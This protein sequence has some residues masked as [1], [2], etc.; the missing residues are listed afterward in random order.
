MA[1]NDYPAPTTWLELVQWGKDHYRDRCFEKDAL[2]PTRPGL[3]YIVHEGVVRLS[4]WTTPC[5]KESPADESETLL[6]FYRFY[7]PFE[8]T[9]SSECALNA[10]AHVN[11]T[12]VIWLYWS[13][14]HQWPSLEQGVF[15]KFHYHQQRQL[16][17]ISLLGQKSTCDRLLK[18]LMLLIQDGGECHGHHYY[19]P[20]PLTHNQMG[21]AI[22]ATR[23]TITRLMVK[24]RQQGVILEQENNLMAL[25]AE[26]LQQIYCLNLESRKL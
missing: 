8:I 16:R 1:L 15:Q 2:I 7:Q 4:S 12:S 26:K 23:V 25:D 5:L 14:L 22:R 19:L 11:Q 18:W 9:V 21:N 20:Y 10:F 6:S 24:L 17:L 13:E 3:V